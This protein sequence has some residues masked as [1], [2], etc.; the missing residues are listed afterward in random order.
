MAELSEGGLVRGDW[1]TNTREF[2]YLLRPTKNFG[3]GTVVVSLQ[4][5]RELTPDLQCDFFH[6]GATSLRGYNLG[7][8]VAYPP[9]N[10]KTSPTVHGKFSKVPD[11]GGDMWYFPSEGN[12]FVPKIKQNSFTIFWMEKGA[13]LWRLSWTIILVTCGKERFTRGPPKKNTN[14]KILFD[15]YLDWETPKVYRSLRV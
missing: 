5:Q 3:L 11:L 2:C 6:L 4:L 14:E 10:E 7:I 15:C 12:H 8:K 13:V 1:S 9:G